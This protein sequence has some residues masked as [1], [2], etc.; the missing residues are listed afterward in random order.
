MRHLNDPTTSPRVAATAFGRALFLLPLA[1]AACSDSKDTARIPPPSLLVQTFAPDDRSWAGN[2]TEVVATFTDALD[3]ASLP[4]D[5]LVV[6]TASG[7]VVPGTVALDGRSLKFVPSAALSLGNYSA[8]LRPDLRSASARLQSSSRREWSFEVRRPAGVWSD[9][10][11][12]GPSEARVIDTAHSPAGH[13]AV[14]LVNGVDVAVSRYAPATGWEAA[15]PVLRLPSGNSVSNVAIATAANATVIAVTYQTENAAAGQLSAALIDARGNVRTSLLQ[16]GAQIFQT[17]ASIDADGQAVVAWTVG[18]PT[19]RYLSLAVGHVSRGIDPAIILVQPVQQVDLEAL[20]AS[21]DGTHLLVFRRLDLGQSETGVRFLRGGALLNQAYT[22]QATGNALA[23]RTGDNGDSSI[24]VPIASA[25]QRLYPIRGG[26][27]QTAIDLPL[28]RARIFSPDLRM[29][30]SR[31]E[32]ADGRASLRVTEVD[33][34]GAV[35]VELLATLSYSGNT[36]PD[37][38]LSPTVELFG[39]PAREAFVAFLADGAV[40]FRR[41]TRDPVTGFGSWGAAQ[42]WL[43]EV[44]P[45]PLERS[46]PYTAGRWRTFLRWGAGSPPDVRWAV[47]ALTPGESIGA[48]MLNPRTPQAEEVWLASDAG[49]LFALFRSQGSLHVQ[50]FR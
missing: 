12:L 22:L 27:L 20:Q 47:T 8:R 18:V 1:L 30:G 21:V 44:R 33:P 42:T 2:V 35:R 28:D 36:P 26:R 6:R 39:N 13:V 49:E 5:A 23:V 15:I 43:D 14:A 7:S 40:R 38:P 34:L 9:P 24:V 50:T 3:A 48:P 11:T 31:W 16:V 17:R 25:Q 19:R 32:F 10:V 37:V 45:V 4:T 46:Q 41:Y 29:F